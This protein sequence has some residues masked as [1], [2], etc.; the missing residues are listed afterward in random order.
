ME[1]WSD[2]AVSDKDPIDR[3]TELSTA[4]FKRY[5]SQ[6]AKFAPP[7]AG[8]ALFLLYFYANRFYPSFDLLQFSSLLLGAGMVG[9][10]II[11]SLLLWLLL[12]G[13]WIFHWFI[14]QKDIRNGITDRLAA[15]EEHR[16]KLVLWMFFLCYVGP[17]CLCSVMLSFVLTTFPGLYIT[18][19]LSLSLATT[20]LSGIALQLTFKLP[21]FA[22]FRYAFNAWLPVCVVCAMAFS[23]ISDVK[24]F[25]DG[26][27]GNGLK[28]L[29]LYLIPLG[30]CLVAAVSALGN[31]GGLGYAIHFSMIFA[32]FIAFYSGVLAGLPAR[33]MSSLGLGNYQAE[34]VL[35][36]AEYCSGSTPKELALSTDCSL[37]D[38]HVVW[39]MGE[40]LILSMGPDKAARQVQIPSRFVKAIVRKPG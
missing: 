40:T 37:K 23:V 30:A 1:R 12:P 29:A 34:S 39:S 11:G 17:Y 16:V 22:C 36:E 3:F 33:T 4:F 7:A 35:L 15:S 10:T 28:L 6:I 8:F 26:L 38:A 20:L 9:F 32:L 21:K 19:L 14:E 2:R 18:A 27:D 5:S 25:I 24:P 13:L 31:F